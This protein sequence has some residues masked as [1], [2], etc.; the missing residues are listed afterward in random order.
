MKRI[1]K[2]ALAILCA[3]ALVLGSGLS[4][5]SWASDTDAVAQRTEWILYSGNKDFVIDAG[6]DLVVSVD[7]ADVTLPSTAKEENLSLVVSLTIPDTN[8]LVSLQDGMVELA[9]DTFDEAEISWPL[10]ERSLKVGENVVELPLTDAVDSGRSIEFSLEETINWFRIYSTTSSNESVAT[11]EEVKL[12]DN[13]TAGLLFGADKTADTYLQ[14]SEPLNNAPQSIEASVKLQSSDLSGM[15]WLLR[16]GS[17]TRTTSGQ[18]LTMGVTVEGDAPGAGMAYAILDASS[19][20]QTFTTDNAGLN[21]D[22]S[23]CEMSKLAVAFWAYASEAGSLT[24]SGDNQMRISSSTDGLGANFLYYPLQDVSVNQ[25]WNY[26]E[27]PLDT[28]KAVDGQPFDV[29]DIQRIG[30][31]PFMLSAGSSRYL[32]D[33]KLVVMQ[34][35]EQGGESG[36]DEE[37]IKWTLRAG[38]DTSTTSGHTLTAGTTTANDAPG[39]GES[40]TILDASNGAISG[41]GT[42]N[43]NLGIDASAYEKSELAVAFWVYAKTAGSLATGGQMRFGSNVDNVYGNFLYYPINEIPVEAGWNYITLPLNKWKAEAAGSFTLASLNTLAIGEG[44]GLAQ[45][46]VR[47]FGDIELIVLEPQT[48]WVLRA[49]ASTAT[50]SGH[51]LTTGTTVEGDAPGAGMKYSVLDA[52]NGAISGF[53]TV[54]GNLGIDASKYDMTEL[55]VAFWVYSNTDGKLGQGDHLRIGSNADNVYGNCL[56]YYYSQID[57][58]AGWNYIELPLSK[59]P[60]DIKGNF[61]VGNINTFAFTAYN[62]PQG[63]I[64]YFGD[65]KLVVL[66]PKTEWTLHAGTSFSGVSMPVGSYTTT[67]NDG[68]GAG[69]TCFTLDASN[70]AI[71]GF[72]SLQTRLGINTGKYT[73]DDLAV[74]FWVYSNKAGTLGADWN[75]HLRIGSNIDNVSGNCLFYYLYEVPVEAGWNY[76][77]IPLKNLKTDIQGTFSLSNINSW[78]ITSY[79]VPQGTVRYFGDF[80]LIVKQ[81]EPITREVLRAGSDTNTSSGHTVTTGTTLAGDKPGADKAY[82]IIDATSAAVTGFGTFNNN[83]GIDASA[84]AMNE[85]AVAFWVYSNKA[86]TLGTNEQLR[87]GSG[88]YLGSNALIYYYSDIQ[89]NAGWN[90]IRL[91]LDK[92]KTD[93]KQDFTLE[94]IDVFGFSG[95][96]LDAGHIRCFGDIELINMTLVE[97]EVPEVQVTVA[98]NVT[99]LANNY[100]IF[101]NTNNEDETNPYALFITQEGYP[102]LLWGTTQLTL[103][104]DVCTGEWVDIA[105]VMDE[106]GFATFY[107]DGEVAARSD[108][109]V[110]ALGEPVTA[111]SIGADGAG[112][113][114]MEGHIADIRVWGDIRTADEIKENLI[115]KAPGITGNG[116]NANTEDLLGSWFLLGNIQHVLETM[117]DTSANANTA[118]YKGSR[119]DD[120]I[121]YVMPEE[122]GEDYWSIVFV[123]DIQNLIRTKEYNKTWEAMGDWIAENAEAENIQHVIGAGDSTWNATEEEFNRAMAG[124][125]KFNSLIPTNVIIGNHDYQWGTTERVS[126]MYPKYFGEEA[127]QRTAAATTYQ[128]YFDDPAGKSTTEN[129]YYRFSING[130]KWMILQLEYHPRVS[131]MEW[132]QEILEAYPDDNVILTTHA[133]IDGWGEYASN[134]YMEYTQ[135][136]A[137]AGGSIG[138]T[139]E[140]I[141]NEYLKDY[142]NIKMILCGHRHNGTGSVVERIETNVDGEE[143]PALMINAQDVD[144]GDGSTNIKEEAYYDDKPIGMLGI[145]R[146]SADGKNVAL[147]YYAPTAEKSFSP[148]DPFGNEDSNNLAYT[149]RVEECSHKNTSVKINVDA[150]TGATNGYTGDTYCTDCET[151]IATG[152]LVPA[153]GVKQNAGSLKD[154]KEEDAKESPITGDFKNP[155][156]WLTVLAGSAACVYGINRKNRKEGK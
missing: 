47:Y 23:V 1:T 115:E 49:G 126:T 25:G 113:Q 109:S 103:T 30:F 63:Q 60:T 68:P 137:N 65:F 36:E 102:A 110:G 114:I 87:I 38:N 69:M 3:F 9:Q 135:E 53:N 98:E 54:N 156:L 121:D 74:A 147:Q 72:E 57:V 152:E 11:L 31:T 117:P 124:F 90:Y 130:T 94:N 82:T 125:G 111:H 107:I 77:E 119:A 97:D 136:D 27:L 34:D 4:N 106:A 120:W 127:L 86:G 85:L 148:E 83:L 70:A 40:Y 22:A 99:E 88:P 59:W 10:Q 28:W 132:A 61:S 116:L 51:T 29:S 142:T 143:V 58:K 149:I 73:K 92:W 6:G 144:A 32:G 105:V 43:E 89:V 67:E 20:A 52:T 131:V 46:D 155:I 16:A 26:I 100:M 50:T 154:E 66:E 101:S 75:T 13:R 91:P 96:N 93:I 21:I 71:T 55:A 123:P 76:I 134:T 14:L 24:A 79:N 118:I 62:L 48:E 17:D 151:M 108:I 81:P 44:F 145:L 33:I 133:Y 146:F 64:R 42:E 19:G 8:A 7:N 84:S 112:G 78:G 139:S 153:T 35:E 41:F 45:G 129:S 15:E 141:W 138:D 37:G 140:P 80:E 122:I 150:A 39:A 128:G 18:T 95:Y 5:I 104:K 56:I 2:R 12:V